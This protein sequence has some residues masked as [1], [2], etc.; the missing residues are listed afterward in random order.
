MPIEHTIQA[1]LTIQISCH[2]CIQFGHLAKVSELPVNS[3]NALFW[4]PVFR[5]GEK[6]ACSRMV[7]RSALTR[8]HAV[9]ATKAHLYACRRDDP[10]KRTAAPGRGS[11]QKAHHM[12]DCLT[13]SRSAPTRGRWRST[14][15]GYTENIQPGQAV[16]WTGPPHR[17]SAP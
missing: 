12:R 8:R 13:H 3:K 4:D 2:L 10:P 14:R 15:A 17:K 7:F 1:V 11:Y 5:D 6:R 16:P 9:P